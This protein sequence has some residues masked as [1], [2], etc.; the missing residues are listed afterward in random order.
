MDRIPGQS[1]TSGKWIVLG[2]GFLGWLFAGVQLGLMPFAALTISR[3]LMGEAFTSASAGAW[4][5]AYSAV[6]MFGA[7]LGGILFGHLGDRLGR[8]RGL[9]FSM[10]C[11]TVFGLT[12]S[13]AQ[14]QEH[15]LLLRFLTGLGVGGTWPNGVSLMS[16][17]WTDVSRPALA[18]LMGA[19]ANLGILLL[20]FVGKWY[21][22]TPESWRGLMLLTG[23][24]IVLALAAFWLV[25]ESPK[26]LASRTAVATASPGIPLLELFRPPLLRTTALGILIGAIPLLGAWA[27]SK[28]MLP[29]ADHVAG[30]GNPGYKAIVLLCWST[31]ATI[32]GL[33]GGYV[34]QLLGRRLSYTLISLCACGMN[35][36]IYELLEPLEAAFLPAVFVQGVISTMFFGWL[37]LYLPEIFPTRVRATGTG[38]SYNFGRFLTAGGVMAAGLLIQFFNG[39]YARVGAVTGLV[40]ALGAVVILWAPETKGKDLQG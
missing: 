24:P 12:G 26:W 6:T 36:F 17:F 15:L 39:E 14:T 34:G 30:P 31:G 28:W 33:T 4:F 35:L 19:A 22:V 37:P 23:S 5:A 27:S 8:S 20:S 13:L 3:A 40:Y 2:A 25:P 1:S 38:I 29:W 16:E 18:G 32:G 11:F 9:A 10:L 7:A 21:E